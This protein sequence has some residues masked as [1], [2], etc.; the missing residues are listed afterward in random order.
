MALP[1]N[2]SYT[3]VTG[4]FLRAVT[5][6]TGDLDTLPDSDPLIGLSVT[7]TP[8][9]SPNRVKNVGAVPPVTI[10]IDPVEATT[11]EEGDIVSPSGDRG[12]W[13]VS[14]DDPDLNPHG[15]TY[16]ARIGGTGF[17]TV[18]ITFVAP[19]DAE[20]DIA[21]LMPVPVNPGAALVEWQAAVAETEANA[22]RA[23]AAADEAAATLVSV[24]NFNGT[25][26]T[27]KRVV[28]TLSADGNSVQGM[29]VENI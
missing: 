26:A 23:E 15:W 20:L 12:V 14:S 18:E 29:T 27:N 6:T 11:N 16:T 8:S 7:F 10:V 9:L 2:I 3:R 21:T 28:I 24:R 5:D 4:R 1:N 19:S 25:P 22:D 17:P 13:L